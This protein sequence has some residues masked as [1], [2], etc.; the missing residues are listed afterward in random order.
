MEGLSKKSLVK[1]K[2]IYI[3][4]GDNWIILENFDYPGASDYL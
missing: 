1:A 3:K 2:L 4:K